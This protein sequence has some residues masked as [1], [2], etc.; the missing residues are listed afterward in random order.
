MTLL[1]HPEPAVT[2]MENLFFLF[3]GCYQNMN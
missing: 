3:A 1:L 2:V